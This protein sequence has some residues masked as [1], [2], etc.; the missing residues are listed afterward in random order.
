MES[1]ID[2]ENEEVEDDEEDEEAE[3]DEEDE[4][5]DDEDVEGRRE[6]VLNS[7]SMFI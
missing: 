3:D 2:E 4:I 5:E 6:I 1:V 7:P